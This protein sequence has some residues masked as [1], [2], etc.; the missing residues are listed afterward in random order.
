[1]RC[2]R[3]AGIAIEHGRGTGH[4]LSELI[5]GLQFAIS[6]NVTYVYERDSHHAW[7]DMLNIMDGEHEKREVERLLGSKMKTKIVHRFGGTFSDMRESAE[8]DWRQEAGPTCYE[9]SWGNSKMCLRHED[10]A[11]I[12]KE[13]KMAVEKMRRGGSAGMGIRGRLRSRIKQRAESPLD[14][15]EGSTS[16]QKKAVSIERR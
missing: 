12:G 15:G 10:H 4:Y 1:M 13:E 2:P 7:L 11:A 5:L 9:I 6:L 14:R 3:F 8:D 16:E